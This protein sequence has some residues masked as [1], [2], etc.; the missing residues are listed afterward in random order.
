MAAKLKV[1]IYVKM[2]KFNNDKHLSN[3]SRNISS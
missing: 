3:D 2:V 1:M